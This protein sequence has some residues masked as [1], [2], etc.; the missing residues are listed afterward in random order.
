MASLVV[1]VFLFSMG[2]KPRSY[3]S[4]F[5]SNT[6]LLNDPRA[7][8][9]YKLTSIILSVLMFYMMIASIKC[10]MQASK[11]GSTENSLILLSVVVTYG[12]ESIPPSSSLRH[13]P[14]TYAVYLFSSL[15]AFDPWHMVTSFVQYMLLSP[16]Y[17][18]I[19]N[20]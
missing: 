6:V 5:L 1:A 14:D 18:N 16:T 19:L 2:N 13:H 17:I 8:W 3:G 10:A 7:A 20:V 12:G 11:Q 15:L 9:K 4:F